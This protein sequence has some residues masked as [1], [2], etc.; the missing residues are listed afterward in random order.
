MSSGDV[1][2]GDG[3]GQLRLYSV[4]EAAD[5]LQTTPAWLRERARRRSVPYRRLGSNEVTFTRSDL[6]QI[7][8]S[9][10]RAPTVPD[11]APVGRRRRRA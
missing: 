11:N 9:A 2:E 4:E 1:V 7:V 5:L 10:L 6:E 3:V 8:A